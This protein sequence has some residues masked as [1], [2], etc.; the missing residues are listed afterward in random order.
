MLK[1]RAPDG[2][3]VAIKVLRAANPE[4]LERFE[5]ERRLQAQLGEQHGF[6]PLL[7]AGFL[8]GTGPYIV[9]AFAGGGTL[10]R[11]LSRSALAHHDVRRLGVFMAGAIGRAHELGIVHRDLKPENILFTEDGRPLIADLGLAKHFD[12]SASGASLSIALS[13]DGRMSGTVGYMAPEQCVDA[14]SAGPPADVF[15]IGTILYEALAGRP[16]FEAEN[17]VALLSK[18]AEARYEPLSGLA[19]DAP[20]WLV[21]VIERCLARDP[22]RRY[23]DGNALAQALRDGVASASTVGSAWQGLEWRPRPRSVLLWIWV[24]I[25]GLVVAGAL[26][27]TARFARPPAPD[28]AAIAS[29]A[30]APGLSAL[31]VRERITTLRL[32]NAPAAVLAPV[33]ARL[34]QCTAAEALAALAGKKPDEIEVTALIDAAESSV[35]APSLPNLVGEREGLALGTTLLDRYARLARSAADRATAARIGSATLALAEARLASNPADAAGHALRAGAALAADGSPLHAFALARPFPGF[36]EG[37]APFRALRADLEAASALAGEPG[38]RAAWLLV[39]LLACAG[40]G[41]E[42]SAIAGALARARERGDPEGL[43]PRFERLLAEPAEATFR[44]LS[45]ELVHA[46]GHERVAAAA[47]LG[48]FLAHQGAPDALDDPE[49]AAGLVTPAAALLREPQDDFAYP[50]RAPDAPEPPALLTDPK[51]YFDAAVLTA[52]RKDESRL[53]ECRDLFATAPLDEAIEKAR[54][55]G[56]SWSSSVVLDAL[57][58]DGPEGGQGFSWLEL[59]TR[60]LGAVLLGERVQGSGTDVNFPAALLASFDEALE[61]DVEKDGIVARA[62]EHGLDAS[63]ALRARR[64]IEGIARVAA[65]RDNP[66]EPYATRCLLDGLVRLSGLDRDRG[67]RLLPMRAG[68]RAHA[69]PEPLASTLALVDLERVARSLERTSSPRR[70]PGAAFLGIQTAMDAF[71]FCHERGRKVAERLARV[72]LFWARESAH[73]VCDWRDVPVADFEGRVESFLAR[74]VLEFLDPKPA[75]ATP[76]DLRR[77]PAP[78]QPRRPDGGPR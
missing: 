52:E 68:I 8:P 70:R 43:G 16:A 32:A 5:R 39:D 55:L 13:A 64:V 48:R 46:E 67:P 29:E 1:A 53:A 63:A 28:V 21:S 75:K 26:V 62:V 66:P 73:A 38:T 30:L 31:A 57:L 14:S 72:G 23:P 44:A 45:G 50:E 76:E 18:V 3:F 65:L 49:L 61:R 33:T 27:A 35:R 78:F 6:V 47:L 51:Q 4:R 59:R 11:R 58:G 36:R 54:L 40:P 42:A 41:V 19:L 74:G 2:R 69:F 37:T 25:V 56:R 20:R 71:D 12:R 15:A 7:D 77:L 34:D 17:T 10:R 9:L 60:A 24:V 22:E